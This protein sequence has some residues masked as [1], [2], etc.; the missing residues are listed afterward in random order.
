MMLTSDLTEATFRATNAFEGKP[1]SI[2]DTIAV[3]QLA[4]LAESDIALKTALM[5]ATKKF[6]ENLDRKQKAMSE[7]QIRQDSGLLSILN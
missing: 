4:D 2:T 6:C 5:S 1:P 7:R 3:I